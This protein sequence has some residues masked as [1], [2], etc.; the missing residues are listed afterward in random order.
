MD[1]D[2]M[3]FILF[4]WSFTLDGMATRLNGIYARN[5]SY[6]WEMEDIRCDF[7]SKLVRED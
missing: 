2:T 3:A 5:V 6:Q 1:A 4:N 7:F